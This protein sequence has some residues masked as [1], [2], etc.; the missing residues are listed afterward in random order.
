VP[1]AP[2]IG[3]TTTESVV[4]TAHP[5]GGEPGDPGAG[6]T[7]DPECLVVQ[8]NVELPFTMDLA[9]GETGVSFSVD[10]P[11]TI[12]P[13]TVERIGSLAM[14]IERGDAGGEE[15]G[16]RGVVSLPEAR[17]GA[18]TAVIRLL[19]REGWGRDAHMVERIFRIIEGMEP[20]WVTVD[21]LESVAIQFPTV[22]RETLRLV[23][24]TM[25]MTQR[26]CVVRLTRAGLRLGP[27]VDR[28]RLAFVELDLDYAERYSNSH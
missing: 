5:M 23:I 3:T 14:E 11:T 2:D 18:S 17:A 15:T 8:A 13:N 10:I 27:R 9:T 24:M 19:A 12:G 7:A 1:N 21:V 25:T 20:P 28:D 4:V 22:D 16:A 26:R 6:I